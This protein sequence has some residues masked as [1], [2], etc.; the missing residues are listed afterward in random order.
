[1]AITELGSVTGLSDYLDITRKLRERWPEEEKPERRGDEQRL[2]FRGQRRLEWGLSPKL[3]REPYNGA[4]ENEI[5]LEFQSQGVQLIPTRV[6]TGKTAKWDWYFLMQHH[7]VPTRLLDWTENP[8][9]GLFFAV[10]VE[11]NTSDS[12]VWALDPWWLNKKLRLGIEGPM[13]PDYSESDSYLPE[14]E[15]AFAGAEV[16]RLLP[17]AIDPPHVDRRVAAQQSRFL[18]FG[19]TQDLTRSKPVKAR[20]ARLARIRIRKSARERLKRDLDD[21]GVNFASIYPDLEGLAL[22]ILFR[23]KKYSVR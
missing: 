3:Y 12:A 21:C 23:W 13:L 19:T 5:R 14:L 7:D 8:L 2:W 6:P 10:E 20:G 15:K 16:R 11:G 1:M 17:A 18:V 22:H 4:D 9:V